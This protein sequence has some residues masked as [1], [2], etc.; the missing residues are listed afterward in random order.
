MAFDPNLPANHS[1]IVSAE[2]RD[3]FAGLKALIDA[4]QAQITALQMAI[5]TRAPKPTMGEFDPGFSD[6]PTIQDLQNVQSVINDLITQL[7]CN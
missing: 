4:Q 5:T 3:Q 6:P 2:L 1:P 7:E